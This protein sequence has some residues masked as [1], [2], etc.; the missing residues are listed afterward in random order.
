M[1][2][3][4]V[5]TQRCHETEQGFRA[6]DGRRV[7][8]YAFL[9]RGGGELLGGVG[10]VGV[11]VVEG[12]DGA[13]GMDEEES[14]GEEGSGSHGGGGGGDGKGAGGSEAW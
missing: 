13:G 3:L 10:P 7:G 6:G 12:E 9:A 14:C 4:E 2:G 8:G 5:W 11:G 1:R